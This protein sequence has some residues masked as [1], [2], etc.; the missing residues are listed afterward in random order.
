MPLL[1]LRGLSVRGMY[2]SYPASL[3]FP[4]ALGFPLIIS[5]ARGRG[6]KL[7][8]ILYEYVPG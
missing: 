5:T 7:Y 8:F 2:D 3:V 1:P 6:I 4:H